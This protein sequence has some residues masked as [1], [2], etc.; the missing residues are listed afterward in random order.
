MRFFNSACNIFFYIIFNEF[1]LIKKDVL[2]RLII[3]L[4]RECVNSVDQSFFTRITYKRLYCVVLYI[5]K[6][7]L[8]FQHSIVN[9]F[10]FSPFTSALISRQNCI[11][12]SSFSYFQFLILALL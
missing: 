12:I 5:I 8:K 3:P 2:E 9:K 4:V 1:Q 7:F 10:Y 11:F 6:Y